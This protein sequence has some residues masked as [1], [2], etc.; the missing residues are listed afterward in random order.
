[1]RHQLAAVAAVLTGARSLLALVVALLV[2]AALQ[3]TAARR[4]VAAAAAAERLRYSRLLHD[5]VLQ[6]VEMLSRPESGL[7]ELPRRQVAMDAAWLRALVETGSEPRPA[8][9][10]P[11]PARLSGAGLPLRVV[12][13]SPPVG[14][15][16]PLADG[17]T[18]ALR[19]AAEEALRNVRKHAATDV[20]HVIADP[21]RDGVEVRIRDHGAGF[22]SGV[23]PP[24]FGLAHSIGSRLTEVGGTATV[25]S[26]VG[27]GTEVRLFVPAA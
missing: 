8:V 23:T 13:K 1:M 26:R 7:A 10:G 20:A 3:H 6:T 25:S 22:D 24:G 27:R 15:W 19:D 2:L 11:L 16:P 5:H 14:S 4:Q 12:V 18:R 17:A 9:A 21:R